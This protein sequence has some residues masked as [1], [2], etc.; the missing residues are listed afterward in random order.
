[1]LTLRLIH[2]WLTVPK[3]KKQS[4]RKP[5]PD[6]I[7]SWDFKS[8]DK[9]DAEREADRVDADRGKKTPK[10]NG[11]HHLPDVELSAKGTCWLSRL[12][13]I[14]M[15]CLYLLRTDSQRSREKKACSQRERKGK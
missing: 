8:W 11:S 14:E 4:A 12:S 10:A 1:M 5:N 2:P 6:Q 7:K 13:S 9:Y 15:V 3:S